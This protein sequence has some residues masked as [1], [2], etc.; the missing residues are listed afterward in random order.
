MIFITRG[1]ENMALI[2]Y[3][4]QTHQ[5]NRHIGILLKWVEGLYFFTSSRSLGVCKDFPGGVMRE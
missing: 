3:A 5:I 1:E 2:D 4:L